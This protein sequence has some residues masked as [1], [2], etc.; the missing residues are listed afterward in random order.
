LDNA[1]YLLS[2]EDKSSAFSIVKYIL[3]RTPASETLYIKDKKI[4]NSKRK[5]WIQKMDDNMEAAAREF[6]S[7]YYQDVTIDEWS[8][9]KTDKHSDKKAAK[10][11]DKEL[12]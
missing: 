7:T 3:K 9:S 4:T 5:E 8:V 12:T 10:S 2:A 6:Q 11:L 1:V